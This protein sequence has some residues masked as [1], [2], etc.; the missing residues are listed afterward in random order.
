MIVEA[1][2][3]NIYVVGTCYEPGTL[4]KFTLLFVM[5]TQ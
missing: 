5:G 4:S 2:A 1:A 3:A